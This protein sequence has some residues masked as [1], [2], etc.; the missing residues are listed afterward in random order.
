[1]AAT[2]VYGCDWCDDIVDKDSSDKPRWA[3]T[4]TI[5]EGATVNGG[6]ASHAETVANKPKVENICRNC[7][8]ALEALREGR[9]RRAG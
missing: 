8:K 5:E 9:Y 6:L 3:A 7:R 4:V 2:T 1:M